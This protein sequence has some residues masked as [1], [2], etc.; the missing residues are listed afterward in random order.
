MEIENNVN[1]ANNVQLPIH[2]QY[3]YRLLFFF[4]CAMFFPILVLSLMICDE[5]CRFDDNRDRFYIV[6]L[7]SVSLIAGVSCVA[8]MFFARELFEADYAA[9]QLVVNALHPVS[10]TALNNP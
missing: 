9:I 7:V 2:Q 3:F 10:P 8:T 4:S 1:N 6:Q 5:P